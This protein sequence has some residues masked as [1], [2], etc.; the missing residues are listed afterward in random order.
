[1]PGREGIADSWNHGIVLA[2]AEK[3]KAVKGTRFQCSQIELLDGTKRRHHRF[4]PEEFVMKH[5]SIHNADCMGLGD[6]NC[7]CSR[8]SR[9]PGE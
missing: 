5:V 6:G 1:M 3:D 2:S 7:V 4:P 9:W 8:R